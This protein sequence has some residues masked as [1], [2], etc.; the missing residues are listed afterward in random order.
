MCGS[1]W[2]LTHWSSCVGHGGLAFYAILFHCFL[3]MN[4]LAFSVLHQYEESIEINSVTAFSGLGRLSFFPAFAILIA[5]V[6]LTGLPPTAGFIAKL[7]IFSSL[8]STYQETQNMML[9]ALFIIGLVNTVIS[10]F[11]Y[12]KIPYSLFMKE[13][14][15]PVGI[16]KNS[17]TRNLLHGIL[18]IILIYLF[19]QPD[20][21]MGWIN[22]ITFVL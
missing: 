1:G 16:L 22:R 4:F 20:S 5:M 13:I 19:L 7:L 10:L 15:Q 12:L 9:L 18:V 2:L 6:A 17:L 14:I 3:L 8:W 21:L 11:F